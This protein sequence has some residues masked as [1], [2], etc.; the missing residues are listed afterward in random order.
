MGGLL[1]FKSQTD[2]SSLVQTSGIPGSSHQMYTSYIGHR[3]Q[4]EHIAHLAHIRRDVYNFMS[5]L[6]VNEQNVLNVSQDYVADKIR[7]DDSS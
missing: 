4:D 1:H 3:Y 2:Y 5:A 7:F 6:P